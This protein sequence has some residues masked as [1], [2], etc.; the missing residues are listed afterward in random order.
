VSFSPPNAPPISAPL[1]PTLTF[2]MPQ[3]EPRGLQRHDAQ[4]RATHRR[5]WQRGGHQPVSSL[6]SLATRT[7]SA[8]APHPSEREAHVRSED[9]RRQALRHAVVHR[10]RLLEGLR[11]PA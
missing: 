7:R 10:H 3:S 5:R 11:T 2:T 8:D 9:G 1:V 6:A 4:R